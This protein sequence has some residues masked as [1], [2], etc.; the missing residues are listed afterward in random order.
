MR[1]LVLLLVFPLLALVGCGG[2]G[3]GSAEGE[4]APEG[5]EG[6]LAFDI[7]DRT[8]TEGNVDYET[9]P[10]VA[11]N[12]H[13]V[14]A[15]CHFYDEEVPEENVVHSLEHGAVWIAYA[16]DLAEDEVQALAQLAE[17]S[18]HIIVTPYPGLDSPLVLSAWNRQLE[19]DSGSDP[20]VLEFLEAYLDGPTA[21]EVDGSCTG[22]AG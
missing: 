10:P 16:E 9:T 3:G 17:S 2:D 19:V 5:I 4:P 13:P 22:G 21:P 18:D 8:H 1:R 20:R 11:G 15:N 6:V 7:G 12:H 14:W